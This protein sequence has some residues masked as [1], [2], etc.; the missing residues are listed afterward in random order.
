[1]KPTSFAIYGNVRIRRIRISIEPK[2]DLL[3][4]EGFINNCNTISI[5]DYVIFHISESVE[6]MEHWSYD[7]DDIAVH[8]NPDL[9]LV[10]AYDSFHELSSDALHGADVPRGNPRLQDSFGN[11]SEPLSRMPVADFLHL[12][13]CWREALVSASD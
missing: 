3:W 9:R 7:C 4:A 13:F 8:Y 12:L 2:A 11:T 1:M 10:I 6:C 5:V